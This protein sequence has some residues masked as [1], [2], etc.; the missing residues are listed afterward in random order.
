MLEHTIYIQQK[1][2]QSRFTMPRWYGLL[3]AEY[4]N[5]K[6]IIT[7][8][9]QLGLP[10]H[11][12]REATYDLWRLGHICRREII[13]EYGREYVYTEFQRAWN[14]DFHCWDTWNP[15]G[16]HYEALLAVGCYPKPASIG[17]VAFVTGW[18]PDHAKRVINELWR[19]RRLE[20]ARVKEGKA[21]WYV[22]EVA[23]ND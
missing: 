16:D 5:P 7:A 20:R 3:L 12:V 11:Q 23:R 1:Q 22:Y 15:G 18:Q 2:T 9:K 13:S 4:L 6:N 8:A 10:E 14:D 19:A 17:D 21:W